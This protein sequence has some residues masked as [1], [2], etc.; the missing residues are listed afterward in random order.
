[1]S[2]HNKFITFK[3]KISK[4]RLSEMKTEKLILDVGCGDNPQGDVNCDVKSYW[5]DQIGDQ[6]GCYFVNVKKIPNFVQCDAKY[7]PFRDE[8]FTKVIASHVIEHVNDLSMFLKEVFRV[9]KEEVEIKCPHRL[10]SQAKMP[11]HVRYFNRQWFYDNLK[12]F[13]YVRVNCSHAMKELKL[14]GFCFVLPIKFP[15]EVTVKVYKEGEMK[16][17]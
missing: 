3:D 15:S 7:L 12:R 4:R 17:D 5:N 11:H 1:M 10:C 8:T 9:A 2:P 16:R 13:G 6:R 14:F